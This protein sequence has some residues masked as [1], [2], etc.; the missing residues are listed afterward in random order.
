MERLAEEARARA[1]DRR[2]SFAWSP[3]G[4]PAGPPLPRPEPGRPLEVLVSDAERTLFGYLR[5]PRLNVRIH[6][7]GAP[8]AAQP[9]VVVLTRIDRTEPADAAAALPAEGWALLSQGRAALVLDASGEGLTFWPQRAA[10]LHDFLRSRGVPPAMAAYA[11]QDRGW[12][13]AYAAWCEAEGVGADRFG[14]WI[15]DLYIQRTISEVGRRG[16]VM[17]Q[18]RLDAYAARGRRRPRRFISLN[19][20]IRPVKALFLLKLIQ[21][22]LFDEGYISLG[23]LG[24]VG[25]GKVMSRSEFAERLTQ[26]HGLSHLGAELAPYLDTLAQIGPVSLGAQ[27]EDSELGSKRAALKPVPLKEYA[28]SW[29]TVVT[30]SHA[31][32]RLHRITEKPLK[33]I[34]NFH[35]F[36]VLGCLGS[37]RL[38]RAYGFDTFPEMFDESYD[39]MPRL[40][41]RFGQVVSETRRLCQAGQGA[42]ARL[43][44]AAAPAVVFNAWWG[45]VELP[46]LF[47]SH[48]EAQLV[49]DLVRRCAARE[50]TS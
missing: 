22:G 34:L 19:R 33:P 28:K 25:G 30:E 36:L 40:R 21:E 10:A 38:L 35:P 44:A 20:T 32:D 12:P 2:R 7:P 48:I 6:R 14:V 31:S 47:H 23:V 26:V 41:H 27:A 16:E 43:D 37:L 8:L 3:D 46:A 4:G 5:D 9:D 15:H 42:L 45:L 29:F 18:R 24:E 13:G 17:F 50:G 1:A 39:E 11:T 49:D